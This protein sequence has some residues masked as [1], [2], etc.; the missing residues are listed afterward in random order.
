[1]A[2]IDSFCVLV[3]I[4]ELFISDNERRDVIKRLVRT[5]ESRGR[6]GDDLELLRDAVPGVLFRIDDVPYIDR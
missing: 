2:S 5:Y 1:M 6:A 4:E 3:E